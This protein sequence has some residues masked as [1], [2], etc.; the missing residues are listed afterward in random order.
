MISVDFNRKPRRA[1][2]RAA[3]IC[4]LLGLSLAGPRASLCQSLPETVSKADTDAP[5]SVDA[6]KTFSGSVAFASEYEDR[7]L[8]YSH[9]QPV[10]QAE[11]NAAVPSGFYC[12]IWGSQVSHLEYNGSRV[13]LDPNGGYKRSIGNFSV[14]VGLWSWLYPGGRFPVSH[15]RYNT[16][17]SY[18]ELSY[19]ILAVRYW[20]DLKDYFG[21]NERSAALDY[22]I[23]PSGSSRGSHYLEANVHVPLP[24]RVTAILHMGN[25]HIRNYGAFSYRDWRA[26]LEYSP[27][28]MLTLSAYWVTT[29][30]NPALY[31]DQGGL[32]T[33]RAKWVG[34]VRFEF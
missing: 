31:A 30:A 6:A 27:A 1:R 7:G 23:A 13:E 18:A 9:E 5:P 4:G 10:L 20:H 34:F 14:D 28:G 25:E 15:S 11:L 22:H 3:L 19:G 29:N 17:E 32:D 12:G 8:S 2:S 26:G 16:L 33:G 24:K 21:L